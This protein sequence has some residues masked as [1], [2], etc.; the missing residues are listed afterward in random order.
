MW[1]TNA[2]CL[3]VWPTIAR[4][5][6]TTFRGEALSS[7]CGI[8]RAS[9]PHHAE[10]LCRKERGALGAPV[11]SFPASGE[12][13]WSLLRPSLGLALSFPASSACRGSGGRFRFPRPLAKSLSKVWRSSQ[14]EAPVQCPASRAGGPARPVLLLLLDPR[15]SSGAFGSPSL[16]ARL[17]ELVRVTSAPFVSQGIC[18]SPVEADEACGTWGRGLP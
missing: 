9:Q 1:A 15:S 12:E 7:S 5:P 18:C 16:R 4:T 6:R 14:L 3:G 10:S 17:E 8:P 2:T 13:G 11:R